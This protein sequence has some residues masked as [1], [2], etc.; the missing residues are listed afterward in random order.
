MAP[1]KKLSLDKYCGNERPPC[2]IEETTTLPYETTEA[3]YDSSLDT[4][5]NTLKPD[6][7]I[8]PGWNFL[9]YF[10]IFSLSAIG[11]GL[12]IF[13]GIKFKWM[14]KLK[15]LVNSAPNLPQA[16]VTLAINQP[17]TVV[18]SM[19]PNAAGNGSGNLEESQNMNEISPV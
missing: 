5:S 17:P 12:L 1:I 19:V 11:L 18:F 16:T 15:R 14:D 6:V 13:V 7:E 4:E 2:Y 8:H 9:S 10:G 3:F